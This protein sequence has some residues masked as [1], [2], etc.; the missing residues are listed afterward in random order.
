[1][2]E[3]RE[4]WFE[5]LRTAL[6]ARPRTVIRDAPVFN[7]PPTPAAVLVPLFERAKEPY[8]VF[9]RRSENVREHKGQISFPGGSRDP[10]DVT[11]LET[12]LRETREELGIDPATIQILGVLDDYLTVTNFQI[13]PFVGVLP[14]D[15]TY[16]PHSDEVAEVLEIPLR[17]LA[18]PARLRS[19]PWEW[20]GGTREVFYLDAGSC[21]IWGATARIVLQLLATWNSLTR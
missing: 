7:V 21:V 4:H 8:L 2:A 10:R 16:H 9:I 12:A 17:L 13:T 11:L 1:M 20:E 14:P 19:E 18:D 3:S 5:P 6:S 15:C